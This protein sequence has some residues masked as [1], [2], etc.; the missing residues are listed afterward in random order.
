MSVHGCVSNPCTICYPPTT[1]SQVLDAIKSYEDRNKHLDEIESIH[2]K[3]LAKEIK[4]LKD[5]LKNINT[6]VEQ[7]KKDNEQKG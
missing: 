1:M 7:M 5:N 3:E 2:I 4:I 6:L